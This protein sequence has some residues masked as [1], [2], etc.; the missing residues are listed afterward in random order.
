MILKSAAR[1]VADAGGEVLRESCATMAPWLLNREGSLVLP[2]VNPQ[3]KLDS[4]VSTTAK[5]VE[6]VADALF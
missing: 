5:A 2:I 3:G 6:K 4:V 1:R